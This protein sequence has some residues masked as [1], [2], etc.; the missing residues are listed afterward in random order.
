[1][2]YLEAGVPDKEDEMKRM[3]YGSEMGGVEKVNIPFQEKQE[4]LLA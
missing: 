2:F 1:M 3:T 4:C